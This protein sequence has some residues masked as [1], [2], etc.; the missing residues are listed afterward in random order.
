MTEVRKNH[1]SRD[2]PGEGDNDAER[3]GTYATNHVVGVIDKGEDVERA[4]EALRQGG[5]LDSEIHVL[6]GEAAAE[7]LDAWSGRKGLVT[8]LLI[9]TAEL[10]GIQDDE[11]YLRERYEQALR[12]GRFVL[13]LAAPSD[14]RKD[15]AARILREHGGHALA[16]LGRFA[17]ERLSPTKRP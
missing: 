5:F 4:V 17:I 3:P 15:L 10:L 2:V 14:T 6:A 11:M 16:F 7:T 9:R 12:E 8:N 1:D 13:V